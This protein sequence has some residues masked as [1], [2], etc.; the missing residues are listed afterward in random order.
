V[1]QPR[2]LSTFDTWADIP[3]WGDRVNS[4]RLAGPTPGRGGRVAAA[5]RE[6]Y[7]GLRLWW[8]SRHYDAVI[9]DSS[10]YVAVF[11]L[12]ERLRV[13][14]KRRHLVFECLWSHVPGR[15]ARIA[16]TLQ[17][18]ATL[19]P[20]SRGI[21]YARRERD[22][23]SRYFGIRPQ[24][25][26][27]IP[28]HTTLRRFDPSQHA[29]PLT[30]RYVFAGGDTHRDYRTLCRAVDGLDIPV[31]IAVRD[32]TLVEGF[33]MPSN[34]KVLTPDNVEFRRWMLHAYINVVPLE[35]GTLRSAGQQSFLN[36]MAL[37]T[38]VVVTDVEGGRDYIQNGADGVLVEAGNPSA[39]RAALTRLLDDPELVDRMRANAARVGPRYATERILSS[40]LD[41]LVSDSFVDPSCTSF[42]GGSEAT[43]DS[44][45]DELPAQRGWLDAPASSPS[46]SEA[47]R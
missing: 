32:R 3:V 45:D 5:F 40:C 37:G 2:I 47:A 36:A 23:F 19:T 44:P 11:G 41:Y 46:R 10:P 14:S 20:R 33:T 12:L 39:L 18:R 6:V 8:V 4:M 21:V 22:S 30:T 17:F 24:R 7:K 15:L 34:V 35:A 25:F 13:G 38:A 16:K 31:V 29:P 27:F 1:T 43:A 26:V 42:L 9:T 28:Y